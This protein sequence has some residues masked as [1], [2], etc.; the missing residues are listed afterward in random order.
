MPN[1]ADSEDTTYRGSPF[2]GGVQ[3]AENQIWRLPVFVQFTRGGRPFDGS[4]LRKIPFWSCSFGRWS[5]L[6]SYE[7]MVRIVSLV[8][9]VR[10]SCS[11]LVECSVTCLVVGFLSGRKAKSLSFVLISSEQLLLRSL[12]LFSIDLRHLKRIF[13]VFQQVFC[14]SV[15]GK[16]IF[17][18]LFD[19][20][21]GGLMNDYELMNDPSAMLLSI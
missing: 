16:F 6:R 7:T 13:L 18:L 10:S 14:A 1:F 20:S 3:N 5:R 12:Y 17:L 8:F 11:C 15:T 4:R 2:G 21:K 19:P 9:D